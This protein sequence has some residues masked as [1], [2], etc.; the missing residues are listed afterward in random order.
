[1]TAAQQAIRWF[2]PPAAGELRPESDRLTHIKHSAPGIFVWH[3]MC[4][5][6]GVYFLDDIREVIAGRHLFTDNPRIMAALEA[7]RGKPSLLAE[8][9]G[10]SGI[11]PASSEMIYEPSR[12]G[13]S[14]RLQSMDDPEGADRSVAAG[15]IK[16]DEAARANHPVE[17]L[18]QQLKAVE[19]G[20]SLFASELM[21]ERTSQR[22]GRGRS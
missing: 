13:L 20:M 6:R 8:D 10:K 2:L 19:M 12:R 9:G 11:F 17:H 16:Q 21:S 22:G 5:D 3:L 18:A 1:M 7:A 14:A 4:A 15:F